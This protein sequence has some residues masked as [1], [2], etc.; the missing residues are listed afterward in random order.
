MTTKPLAKKTAAPYQTDL[1]YL[2]DEMKWLE[3]R[4][5]RIME[6]IILDRRL[7]EKDT[8]LDVDPDW[9]EESSE[10]KRVPVAHI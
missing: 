4:C 2:Q 1:E 10:E 7:G 6:T 9:F 3:Q 5:I 8:G